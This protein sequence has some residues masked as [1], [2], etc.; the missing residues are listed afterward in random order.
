M[1]ETILLCRTTFLIWKPSPVRRMITLCVELKVATMHLAKVCTHH[2]MSVVATE[3][4][5]W[6]GDGTVK[7]IC[8]FYIGP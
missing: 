5:E 4:R 8:W 1:S 2:F 7:M 6:T 3:G